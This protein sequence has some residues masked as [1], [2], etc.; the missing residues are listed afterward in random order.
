MQPG[1]GLRG[2]PELRALRALGLLHRRPA[3]IV[4]TNSPMVVMIILV[5]LVILLIIKLIMKMI[6]MTMH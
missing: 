4:Y 3:L 5:L 2:P 1:L 6:I